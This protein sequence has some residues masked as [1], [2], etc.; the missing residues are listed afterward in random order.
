[1]EGK[2]LIGEEWV[3][4]DEKIE[5]RNPA[6]GELVGTVPNGGKEETKR[7]IEAAEKAM[8]VWSAFPAGKR[9]R[10]MQ[11][12]TKEII[13]NEMELAEIMTLEMGKP[14][15][16]A[17]GEVR[18]SA[19]YVEWFAEEGKRVYG[20][21][22]PSNRPD[23]RM[24][25]IKQPVGVVGAITPWNFPAAMITRKLGPALAAGCAIVIKPATATPL[26][27]L[28]LAEICKNVGFPPGLVNV[29]TGKTSEIGAEIMSNPTVRKVSFTG[30]TNVGKLLMRQ[31]ADNV[32]KLSLELGGHAPV[33]VFDDANLDKAVKGAIASK[34]RNAGQTCICGNRIYVQEGI[35]E[36]FLAKFVEETKKLQVGNGMEETTDVGPVIDSGAYEKIDEHVQ[37]AIGNGAACL[38]GGQGTS[39][40]GSNFYEP[41]ILSNVTDDMLIM[42]EET[43][44]PVAPVQSF[45]TMEEV[46][47]KANNTEYGLAAYFFTEG[48]SQGMKMAEAL[49]YGIIGWNDGVPTA[50]QAPFGGVKESGIGREGGHQGLAEYLEEKYI[51]IGL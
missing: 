10:Y 36:A 43:F 39:G 33:I 12:L 13:K 28:K 22:I 14:L 35:Y 50:V 18:S 21:T 19:A 17:R 2:M 47:A 37:N 34:F 42:N 51:S 45:K 15:K 25:V 7:A 1:M 24:M 23:Q 8:K 4:L 48:M 30:S 31:A 29:V 40:N 38:L 32:K 9:A 46:I 27:A 41:T 26:T 20:E 3:N 6:T 49:E 16:E 11:K 44:G 5:V